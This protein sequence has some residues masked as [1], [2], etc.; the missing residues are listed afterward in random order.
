MKRVSVLINL[1]STTQLNT[2][3]PWLKRPKLYTLCEKR[4]GERKDRFIQ[5]RKVRRTP[6]RRIMQSKRSLTSTS[7]L[8]FFLAFSKATTT[9]SHTLKHTK[10]TLNRKERRYLIFH[11]SCWACILYFSTKE[12]HYFYTTNDFMCFIYFLVFVSVNDRHPSLMIVS[13]C[14]FNTEK[15]ISV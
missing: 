4:E 15:C 8:S 11:H 7:P 2:I 5:T 9:K 3:V 6:D 10:E 1:R 14:R 12:T 13:Q